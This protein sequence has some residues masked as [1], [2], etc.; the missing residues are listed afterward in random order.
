MEWLCFVLQEASRDAG[1]HVRKWKLKEQY[2]IFF[3][4]RKN[5]KFGRFISIVSIQGDKRSVTIIPEVTFNAGW[6]DIALK[7]RR[8]INAD[9]GPFITSGPRKVDSKISYTKSVKTS[10]WQTKE[11]N[12]AHITKGPNNRILISGGAVNA[13]EGLLG[14][15]VVGSFEEGLV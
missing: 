4:S 5:N 2:S 6:N 15:C 3:S 9:R 8:F 7:N 12:E 13:D 10:K 14:R 1:T 11:S